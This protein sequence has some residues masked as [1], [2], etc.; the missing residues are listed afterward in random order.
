MKRY[1]IPLLL[2]CLLALLLVGCGQE[3]AEP[4][5][6]PVP[7]PE[8]TPEPVVFSAGSFP[9]D[10][11]ELS[12]V[13]EEGET[14]K[15]DRL[16]LLE[17]LTLDGS[18]C[19]E[20][21]CAWAA[22]H[23]AVA[24]HYTLELPI[25]VTVESD[26]TE[27]DLSACSP[28]ELRITA[29]WLAFL[30]K[31]ERID[32]GSEE[33][34]NA[35]AMDDVE[36]LLSCAP[37]A[38]CDYTVT[39]WGKTFSLADESLDLRKVVMYDRGAAVRELLLLMPRCRYLDMDQ[40]NVSNED[41][42]S[43]RDDFPNV[44]VVWRVWFGD[45]YSVRTDVERILASKPSKGGP[46][47]EYNTRALQYCTDV[48]Y[49]DIG[50]NPTLTSIDFVRYMTKLE[51]AIVALC[52][53]EDASPL[54]NCTELEYLEIQTTYVSDLTPLAGLTKL[55]HLNIGYLLDCTDI[56]PLY[57]LTE[58]E[59]LWIGSVT[60]IPEEQVEE[61]RRLVPDCEVQNTIID[62]TA[63][64]WRFTGE[65]V[66]DPEFYGYVNELTPRYALL[67][68]QFG[69]RDADFAFCWNDPKYYK[70]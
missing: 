36:R 5:P 63:G 24:V 10:S 56:T 61:F 38:V 35:P 42:A 15:L 64:T 33:R 66:Y 9:W 70:D 13:L 6:T 47:T 69:Y 54:A 16:P 1:R 46:L 32:L 57:G 50:H 29:K 12:L 49:L 45:N 40:C 11:R 27:L 39:R 31:L 65:V 51:V 53:Y 62:P 14:E 55:H 21:I 34:E 30:P 4:T 23:P 7:T 41:M 2:L 59:R 28:R 37:N 43:I 8:P 26:V 60:P 52:H 18:R 20:E 48:K 3:A 17:T 25:G 67:R 19:Y 22:A 44:K 68:E 58:L